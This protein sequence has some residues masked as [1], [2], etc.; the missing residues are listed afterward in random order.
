MRREDDVN[1]IRQEIIGLLATGP[2][3]AK[4]VSKIVR[5]SEKEVYEHLSHINRSLKSQ[6]RKLSIIPAR[7][8]ECGYVFDI[9]TTILNTG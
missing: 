2:H 5:V 1:T 6:N 8:L 9:S 7:C 3:G 4:A